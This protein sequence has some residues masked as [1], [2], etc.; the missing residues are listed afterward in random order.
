MKFSSI[1]HGN[2]SNHFIRTMFFFSL[3]IQDIV[4]FDLFSNRNMLCCQWEKE[5][6]S[7]SESPHCHGAKTSL[8]TLS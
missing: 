7:L 1:H 8:M 4:L 3:Q 2:I 5:S 6:D